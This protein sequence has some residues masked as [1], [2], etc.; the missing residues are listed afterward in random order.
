MVC[1]KCKQDAPLY[2]VTFRQNIGLI[3]MH[4]YKTYSGAY[5]MKC[6]RSIF[7]STFFT[8][9]FLGW[10]GIKSFFYTFYYMATNINQFIKLRKTEPI[11]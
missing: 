5:C 7:W 3:V 6:A 10:W 8:N 1:A 11:H 4:T 9:L 2:G